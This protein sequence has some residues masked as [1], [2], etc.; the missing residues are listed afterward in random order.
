MYTALNPGEQIGQGE[1]ETGA[2][3]IH[4]NWH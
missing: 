2:K 3:A 1:K 4:C